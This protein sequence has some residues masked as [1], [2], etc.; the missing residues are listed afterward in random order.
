VRLFRFGNPFACFWGVAHGRRPFFIQ[1]WNNIMTTS[2][3]VTIP[4]RPR[5]EAFLAR[6]DPARGRLIFALDATASR[7]PTWDIAAQLQARMFETVAAT[8]GLDVQLVWFRGIDEFHTSPWKSDPHSLAR[9]M[10]TVSCRSGPTQFWTTLNHV[11]KTNAREKINA[12]ILV[13][14]ACEE[15]AEALYAE[16]R[17]LGVPVFLFQEGDN[18]DVH[19]I[20][21]EIARITD[22]AA[23]QFDAGAAARLAD[24]LKAVAAFASGGRKA[25]ASQ[26]T[27]AAR[28]LLTQIKK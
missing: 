28:L 25:L 17:E 22:G 18:P 7:Q 21:A 2:A 11:R 12:L 16:A 19:K 3:S 23:A 8:G 13:G 4:V 26:Q 9:I 14:D 5:V 15:P 27:D 10:S 6:V 24:L 20:F 1:R